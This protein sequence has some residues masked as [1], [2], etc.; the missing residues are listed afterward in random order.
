M[1]LTGDA[2]DDKGHRGSCRADKSRQDC[3]PCSLKPQ[4]V[5]LGPQAHHPPPPR[6]RDYRMSTLKPLGGLKT[7][8]WPRWG[9][10]T[11]KRS[12]ITVPRKEADM[13]TDGADS[14][15]TGPCTQ[16]PPPGV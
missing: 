14:K 4:T 16:G 13:G 12:E 3:G 6:P 7:R 8:W 9:K 15:K 10:K 1:Q 5:T 11:P 2:A